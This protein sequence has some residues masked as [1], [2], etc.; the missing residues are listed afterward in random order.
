M[1][2]ILDHRRRHY[3]DCFSRLQREV[4]IRLFGAGTLQR[5]AGAGI[6]PGPGQVW[7]IN[8]KVLFRE[9]QLTVDLPKE[10][11]THDFEVP[12]S[13]KISVRAKA[14]GK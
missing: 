11:G 10:S 1:Q 12:A 7:D 5:R 9:Y 4:A 13:A 14:R 8:G 3:I 6:P 2:I